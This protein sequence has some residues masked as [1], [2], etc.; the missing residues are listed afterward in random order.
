MWQ[1][2]NFTNYKL[3]TAFTETAEHHT[4]LCKVDLKNC[5]IKI[6]PYVKEPESNKYH[7]ARFTGVQHHNYKL[8]I[9]ER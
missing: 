9:A 4:E 7:V 1:T 2:I 5:F 6:P 3:H 8:D